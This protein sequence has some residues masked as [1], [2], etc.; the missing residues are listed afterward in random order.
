MVGEEDEGKNQNYL[1]VLN[2]IEMQIRWIILLKFL[3]TDLE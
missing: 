2:E 1:R 3:K